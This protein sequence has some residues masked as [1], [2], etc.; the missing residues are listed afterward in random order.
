MQK[1]GNRIPKFEEEDLIKK[2][3]DELKHAQDIREHYERKL[4]RANDLYCELRA[5]MFQ[6]ELREKQLKR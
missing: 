1:N 3:N 4:E 5:A 6:I 2:R